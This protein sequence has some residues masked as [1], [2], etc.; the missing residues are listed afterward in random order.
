VLTLVHAIP[1]RLDESDFECKLLCE[2]WNFYNDHYS[3]YYNDRYEYC[4]NCYGW[5]IGVDTQKG[6]LASP[7]PSPSPILDFDD[8]DLACRSGCNWGAVPH[9]EYITCYE[10]CMNRYVG[11]CMSL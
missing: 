1:A 11:E 5:Q 9:D 4:M 10:C 6:L 3:S 2:F 8:L 7:S